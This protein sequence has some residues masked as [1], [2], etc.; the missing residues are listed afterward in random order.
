[1]DKP[2]ATATNPAEEQ[3]TQLAR[4]FLNVFGAPRERTASQRQVL[5]CMAQM[6]N[7]VKPLVHTDKNGAVDTVATS[8]NAGRFEVFRFIETQV[9]RGLEGA[10]EQKE[11]EVKKG[12]T[13]G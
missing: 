11:I 1:M 10:P 2:A 9:Q 13:H 8:I 12:L 7:A 6:C 4:S 3:A 5:S